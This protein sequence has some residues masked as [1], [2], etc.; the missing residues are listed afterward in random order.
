MAAPKN[1]RDVQGA[2]RRPTRA[3]VL[4][5]IGWKPIRSAALPPAVLKAEN[6]RMQDE[7]VAW[8]LGLWDHAQK[9]KNA[10]KGKKRR[11]KRKSSDS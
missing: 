11:A 9:L 6:R 4:K 1:K 2:D 10:S 7:L 3:E 5:G 8:T